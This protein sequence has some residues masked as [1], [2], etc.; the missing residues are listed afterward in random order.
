MTDTARSNLKDYAAGTAT[1]FA[2][3]GPTYIAT[4]VVRGW[5]GR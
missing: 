5:L 1:A 4:I 3:S 2:V